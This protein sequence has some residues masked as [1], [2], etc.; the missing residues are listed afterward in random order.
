MNKEGSTMRIQNH[1]I[2]E[3][4]AKDMADRIWSDAQG[5]NLYISGHDRSAAF[6][7][8]E[9]APS[10]IKVDDKGRPLKAKTLYVYDW[11]DTAD[12]KEMTSIEELAPWAKQLLWNGE[13]E[14]SWSEDQI[15]A[16]A[17]DYDNHCV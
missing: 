7:S 10:T 6:F 3:K 2:F 5:G 4:L 12:V 17:A 9:S 8:G 11:N 16:W 13:I 14:K 15:R 1:P